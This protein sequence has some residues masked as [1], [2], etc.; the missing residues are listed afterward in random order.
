MKATADFEIRL[1]VHPNSEPLVMWAK[2]I[3]AA[4]EAANT[5]HQ[6]RHYWRIEVW[7]DDGIVGAWAS[8]PEDS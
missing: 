7:S 1:Y 3:H 2:E 4:E 6:T 5:F 8:R